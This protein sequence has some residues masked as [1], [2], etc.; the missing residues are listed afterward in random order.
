[1]EVAWVTDPEPLI[2]TPPCAND[3]LCRRGS[4][5]L[6][7]MGKEG[8]EG[9]CWRGIPG[10]MFLG[11]LACCC[12]WRVSDETPLI[13]PWCTCCD[14]L[15]SADAIG[16]YVA[17]VFAAWDGCCRYCCC[18]FWIEE[19][20]LC[21]GFWLVLPCSRGE[22]GI[23]TWLRCEGCIWITLGS[24]FNIGVLG[25]TIDGVDGPTWIGVPGMI[26]LDERVSWVVDWFSWGVEG[27]NWGVGGP[28]WGVEGPSVGVEGANWGVGGPNCGVEGPN[29]GVDGAN[30]G[31][32]GPIGVEGPNCG[33]EG[34][35]RASAI[36]LTD[37][38]RA[39]LELLA[40]D[41]VERVLWRCLWNW[42][43]HIGP[44]IPSLRCKFRSNM[45]T[46]NI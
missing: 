37:E 43:E 35:W 40:F 13:W 34:D 38:G 9:S 42:R 23:W 17:G 6:C 45:K 16:W 28:N 30:W 10:F 46:L 31:V 21:W 8:L 12:C 41:E 29:V 22:L 36:W 26:W 39:R 2:P 5:A 18:W 15:Y 4:F 3:V 1:M 20:W 19:F 14:E 33:V 27:P 7:W 25:A 11:T 32:G 24:V 44:G